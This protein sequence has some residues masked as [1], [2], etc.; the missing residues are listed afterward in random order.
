MCY[1]VPWEQPKFYLRYRSGNRTEP[2]TVNG[3]AMRTGILLAAGRSR[4]MGRT[5]QLLPW[6]TAEGTKPL[7]A[8]AFDSVAAV[9]DAMIVV[10]GHETEVVRRALGDRTY[11]SVPSDPEAPMFASVRA[12]LEGARHFSSKADILLQ[13]GDHPEL[14]PETLGRLVD[15][16]EERPDGGPPR[17]VLPVAEDPNGR[18]RG[19]HP[20]LIPN[21]MID[22]ILVC[23]CP[24]GLRRF[25]ADHPSWCRRLPVEDPAVLLD[26]DTLDDYRQAFAAAAGRLCR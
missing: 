10:L 17:A 14:R 22:Q 3:R 25:W 11:Y 1:L 2:I 9:C 18:S 20:A 21:R 15:A 23:D 16:F 7:V 19:G 13:P 26:L 8:A 5:K 24:G 6:P 4:R 12:G